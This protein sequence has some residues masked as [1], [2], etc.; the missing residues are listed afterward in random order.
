MRSE[1]EKVNMNSIIFGIHFICVYFISFW[2]LIITIPVH[3][4][5]YKLYGDFDGYEIEYDGPK[6]LENPSYQDYL[7][8][9]YEI[10]KNEISGFYSFNEKI[11]DS[12]K[13]ALIEAHNED[14]KI[15]QNKTRIEFSKRLIEALDQS[16]RST[17][18]SDFAKDFNALHTHPPISEQTSRD[19]LTGKST[20][21]Q[22]YMQSLAEW[23]TVSNDWL[24]QEDDV[25][26]QFGTKDNN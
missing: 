13:N 1:Y 17:N 7:V 26:T 25:R 16:N 22:E 23:L 2:L 8:R 20:P 15:S 5:F 3:L 19:W 21:P 4:L 10:E 6:D 9:E 24:Y 14:K 11:Y 12:L 18:P